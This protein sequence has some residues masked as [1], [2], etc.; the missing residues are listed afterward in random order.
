[1]SFVLSSKKL[2]QNECVC[3]ALKC[4]VAVALDGCSNSHTKKHSFYIVWGCV[5]VKGQKYG[6]QVLW[7]AA[8]SKA[9]RTIAKT[10]CFQVLGAYILLFLA[11]PIFS[12]IS[13]AHAIHTTISCM[14]MACVSFTWAV[15]AHSKSKQHQHT[16]R[17]SHINHRRV[18]AAHSVTLE[19][20]SCTDIKLRSLRF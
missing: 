6:L 5:S 9:H 11:N 12:R 8:S 7:T 1:M 18:A 4:I 13:L 16:V 10:L 17:F 19:H 15:W 2:A 3:D 14:R 20:S